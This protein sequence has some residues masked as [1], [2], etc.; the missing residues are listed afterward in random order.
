MLVVVSPL[1]LI[2]G[3]LFAILVVA[4]GCNSTPN[5]TDKDVTLIDYDALAE[6]MNDKSKPVLLDVRPDYKY[7]LGHLPGAINIPLPELSPTDNRLA[8]AEHVV[9]YGDSSANT[10]SHAAAKKLLAGGK[11]LVSDF[12]GGLEAWQEAGGEVEE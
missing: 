4:T 8:Q 7:R 5:I 10:L 9:V 1:R 11:F 2:I 3:A 6:L 12:R